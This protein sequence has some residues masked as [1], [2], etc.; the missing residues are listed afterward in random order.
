VTSQKTDI[1][2]VG[3]G[4]VGLSHAIA[5]AKKGLNVT[6]F[7]SNQR[8]VGAS[9]RNFGMIWPI[10]Q[11]EGKL[12]QR[13]LRSREIWL[14]IAPKAGID[15]ETSGS[16]HLAYREDELAV[17]E[18]FVST[19]AQSELKIA[20]ISA[21]EVAKKSPAAITEGLLGALWSEAETIVNPR[22][23]LWKLPQFL[24]DTYNIQFQF[25]KV[26]TEINRPH[27]LAGG[28]RWQAEQILICSG[29]DFETLYP[30]I[31][32]DLPI[33]KSKLQML[34][35]GPQPD[36]WRLGASLCGGL[37]LTHY[38]AFAHCHSLAALKD[39]IQLETPHFPQWHIHVMVSQN[40][41]GQLII[42]DSHEYGL[43]PEPFDREELNIYI[44]D[45]LQKM[46]RFPSIA[47]AERWNGVYAKL[48]GKTELILKP[49]TGVT[50]VNALGGAGMTL[51]FGLAEEM[52]ANI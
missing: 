34:S 14:E 7:E 12:R 3:A 50:I 25:G 41:S 48:P 15:I 9:I 43:N 8:V 30:Q 52:F 28:D 13:A 29:S 17:L 51:S 2:I 40:A 22:Q 42:G 45:Y 38:E 16:L 18:E 20:L 36:G 23:A 4:I 26:V 11:P 49:E 44:L 47:I 19:Q 33:T 32:A 1:A 35:T 10:G 37:T 24:A 27:L 31:F 6:V 21:T 46:A 39:R 5:A